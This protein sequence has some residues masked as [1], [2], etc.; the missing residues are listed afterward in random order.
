MKKV[1]IIGL[2]GG[3][4]KAI[5]KFIN[6]LPNFKFLINNGTH[7]IL[8]STIPFLT[9]PAWPS[10]YTGVNPGKHSVFHFLTIHKFNLDERRVY[11]FADVKEKSLWKILSENKKRCL[12][13]NVPM[14]FPPEEI[15]GKLVGGLLSLSTKRFAYPLELENELKKQN[16]VI[17]ASYLDL[18]DMD[19]EKSFKII[20]KIDND[21]F[22]IWKKNYLEEKWDF[23]MI[24]FKSSDIVGHEFWND[25]KKVKTTYQ[26]LDMLLGKILKLIDKETAL[27]IMSDHGFNSY[28][29]T[30]NIMAW[31]NNAGYV[32][33]M[34]S[35]LN[36]VTTK[37]WRQIQST[38]SK[39]SVVRRLLGAVGFDR[40]KLSKN[41]YFDKFRKIIPKS[42]KKIIRHNIPQSTKTINWNKTKAYTQLGANST[43][44]ININLSGRESAGIIKE[45]EYQ[46]LRNELILKLQNLKD[47]NGQK[48]FKFVLPREKVYFGKYVNEAPD[49]IFDS[50]DSKRLIVAR[51]DNDLF[52]PTTYYTNSY[53]DQDGIFFAFGPDICSSKEIRPINIIDIAPTILD[54]MNLEIPKNIDGKI[55][56]EIYKIKK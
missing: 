48:I 35:E 11:S 53:H 41:K 38:N 43:W 20:Q 2:D 10:F 29:E 49:I 9:V 56:R 50:A 25:D 19:P 42:I 52:T 55:A 4:F 12:V 6:A 28:E 44:G 33:Y 22:E 5:K 31:L 27:F 21:R 45:S 51:F 46:K 34:K 13:W 40:Q 26:N 15:N 8:K 30:F 7:G 39:S 1:L 23:S 16:Y 3:T 47:R 37:S 36:D 17:D 14:T 24:V 54:Y 32:E 18:H